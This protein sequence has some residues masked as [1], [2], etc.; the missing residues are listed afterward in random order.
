MGLCIVCQFD[1]RRQADENEMLRHENDRLCRVLKNITEE[2]DYL[3]RHRAI[4]KDLLAW[5]DNGQRNMHELDRIRDMAADLVR[6]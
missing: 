5:Y 1:G 2:R 4:V 6:L 3:K